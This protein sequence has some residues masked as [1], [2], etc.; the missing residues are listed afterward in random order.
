MRQ[1]TI[2]VEPAYD[3]LLGE[4]LLAQAGALTAE[5]VRGRH[6]LIVTDDG[7]APLYLEA[8]RTSYEG[9]GFDVDTFV[10]PHGES[11]KS[12]QT[13]EAVLLAADRADLPSL[14]LQVH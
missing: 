2:P 11:N 3:A 8:A 7:V 6:V 5:A 10:F 4:G 13:V 14:L 9:A 1:L 12:L